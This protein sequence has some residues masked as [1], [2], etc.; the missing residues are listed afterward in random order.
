MDV[1]LSPSPLLAAGE[2]AEGVRVAVVAVDE[3]DVPAAHLALPYGCRAGVVDAPGAGLAIAAL[4]KDDALDRL[5][6]GGA[7]HSSQADGRD[8]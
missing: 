3:D 2:R 7:F 4:D 5:A 1:A 8:L 6:A